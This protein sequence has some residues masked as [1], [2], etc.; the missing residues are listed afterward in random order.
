MVINL[1]S[2]EYDDR[3]RICDVTR[4]SGTDIDCYCYAGFFDKRP[5]HF[6][7]GPHIL[8]LSSQR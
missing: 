4:L 7:Y 1:K 6:L 2:T 5:D 3:T 8:V